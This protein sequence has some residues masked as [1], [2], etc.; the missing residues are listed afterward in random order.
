MKRPHFISADEIGSYVDR[1]FVNFKIVGRG[2]PIDMVID[3]YVYYLALEDD[4][5][6]I[7]DKIKKTINKILGR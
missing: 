7:K 1:G 4:R 6:F 3:S 5:E 2:L